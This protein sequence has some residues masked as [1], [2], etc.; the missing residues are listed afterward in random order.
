MTGR[1]IGAISNV[2]KFSKYQKRVIKQIDRHDLD[3]AKKIV[4]DLHINEQN[5]TILL[6]QEI[7]IN[8]KIC[9]EVSNITTIKPLKNHGCTN[10]A[11]IGISEYGIIGNTSLKIFTPN[12]N[13]AINTLATAV[14]DPEIIQTWEKNIHYIKNGESFQK[15]LLNPTLASDTI[16]SFLKNDIV[17]QLR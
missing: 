9:R 2:I 3:K 7:I 17:N 1:G 13:L 11:R 14:T 15:A 4:P 10:T 5:H 8:G 12:Q 6:G 16:M